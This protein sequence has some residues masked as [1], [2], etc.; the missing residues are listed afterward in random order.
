MA[1]RRAFLAGMGAGAAVVTILPPGRARATP[2][3][4]AEAIR[5]V[6]GGATV[7]EGKVRLD[8]APRADNGNTVPLTV[9]VDHPM[10]DADYVKSIHVFSEN[11]PQPHV[12]SAVLTP[13]NGRAAVGTRIRLADSQKVVAVAETSTGAFWS[14]SADVIVTV[15]AFAGDAS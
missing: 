10:T 1:G 13:R 7:G 4:L 8:I 6:A 15:A 2:E 5:E 11:N 14:A 9:S 3:R 12:F